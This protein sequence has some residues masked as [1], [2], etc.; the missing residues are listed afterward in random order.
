M[1][2]FA[3]RG[4]CPSAWRPMMAGDGLIVRV[5]PRLGRLSRAQALALCALAREYGSGAIDLSR[6]ANLQIR[7]VTEAGWAAL[8]EQLVAL[9]LVDA[10]PDTESRRNILVAPDWTAG[11]DTFRIAGALASA[12][13]RL[14]ELPGKMGFAVDAGAAPILGGSPADFRIERGEGGGLILRADGRAQGIPV[15]VDEAVG[16]LVE[17]AEWFAASGGIASGRMARHRAELPGWARGWVSPASPRPVIGPGA[18]AMGHACGAAFGSVEA[19][20]LASL[21]T[22]SGAGAL[23]ITPWRVLLLEGANPLPDPVGDG[24]VSDPAD[25]AMRVDACPGAP[26]CPQATVATRPL[27]LRL[28]A[29]VPGR[30][31]VSGCA[32]GCARSA[33]ASV[34]LTGRNGRFDLSIDAAAG[35]PP[36]RSGLDLPQLLAHFGAE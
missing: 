19:A 27:A 24:F 17:L 16:A 13:V 30:L 12:Q 3:V 34:T 36:C 25:P 9:E 22:R 28:A 23:R 18:H 32:K 2:D 15:A 4:W 35:D 10:R 5:R 6:R 31:H 21:V 8:L 14:P 1:S 11:D 29:H 33:P 20:A 26:L 7:G